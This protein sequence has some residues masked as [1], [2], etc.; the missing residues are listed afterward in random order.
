LATS[1]NSELNS[2][3]EEGKSASENLASVKQSFS[4][5]NSKKDLQVAMQTNDT[6]QETIKNLET[7]YEKEMNLETKVTPSEDVG[8][9]ASEVELLGAALNATEENGTITFGLSKPDEETQKNLVTNTR[10]TK[11]I[12]LDI[13][14]VGAGITKG[15]KLDIPVT[16]TMPVP[17]GIDDVSRLTVLHYNED[18]KTFETLTVRKNNN[19]TISF[20]VL[21]FSNFVFAEEETP[22]SPTPTVGGSGSSSDNDSSSSSESGSSGDDGSSASNSSSSKGLTLSGAVGKSEPT[23]GTSKGWSSLSNEVDKAIASVAT[24]DTTAIVSINLNGSDTIPATAITAI[25]GKNVTLALLVNANTLV[26]IDGSQLTA[27]DASDIKLISGKTADGDAT[28]NVRSQN[29][30]LQKTIVVYNFMGLD[31]VGSETALYFV[32]LDDSLVEFRNSP[33]YDN[34]FVAYETSLVNANYKMTVK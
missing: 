20:T 5:D 15:Q 22:T 29:L 34:G 30:D 14:L 33:V 6:T 3:I 19:G 21:H 2:S 16:V 10:F 25:A 27:E 8:I 17:S 24:T 23:I 31:K 18:N 1:V 11:A 28:L 12:V 7:S 26:T 4:D 32:N 9:D 13:S